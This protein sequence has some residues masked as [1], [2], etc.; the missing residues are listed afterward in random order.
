MATLNLRRFASPEPLRTITPRYLIRLLEPHR[1]YLEG[2]G[3]TLPSIDSGELPDYDQ[4]AEILANPDRDTPASLIDAIYFVTELATPEG[5][6]ALIDEMRSRGHSLDEG[7][8]QSPIDVAIQ[9]WLVD[10][11]ILQEKHAEQYLLRR[12]SF[13][14][15]QTD[16]VDV[17]EF[18]LPSPAARRALEHALD[19]WFV[20]HKRGTGARVF[21]Y[22]REHEVWF[23]VRHGNPYRREGSLDNGEP[24]SV[25]YRP[26]KFD[27]LVYDQRIGEIRMNAETVGEKTLYR[28]AFG[29][30]FFGTPEFFPGKAKYTLEPLQSD[31]EASL[32]CDDIDG[33]EWVRL[34]EADF[35]WGGP[36]GEIEVRRA[37]DVFA[38]Y[39]RREATFPR[40]V[41]LIKA[42][43]EVKFADCKS[44]R[45]VTI[46]PSNVAQY[47]RDHDSVYVEEWLR[48]RGFI[49]QREADTD[50]E[51]GAVLAGS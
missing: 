40:R 41:R 15:F 49:I 30:H 25:A 51:E 32:E 9:V 36:E 26:L 50:V 29:T 42:V 24:G 33:I 21:V 39:A 44:T 47:T 17:P 10:P 8:D 13:E 38:A 14:Y 48:N 28:E 35:Y 43:F 23:L 31:G 19:E 6:D 7:Q 20:E 27:V 2:R 18:R 5:M 45:A 34:K 3:L 1:A 37:K 16:R 11:D 4:L 12:R 46:K 22:P